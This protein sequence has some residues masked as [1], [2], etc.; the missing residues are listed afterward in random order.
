MPGYPQKGE[1]EIGGKAVFLAVEWPQTI[2]GSF[3]TPPGATP[4]PRAGKSTGKDES[5]RNRVAG[6]ST[7]R[8]AR[9]SYET[10]GSLR[11]PLAGPSMRSEKQKAGTLP[12]HF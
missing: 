11:Q 7:G 2:S 9:V 1:N 10:T 6:P 4:H 8:P 3:F 5:H 12:G